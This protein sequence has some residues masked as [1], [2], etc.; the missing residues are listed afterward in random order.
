MRL[1]RITSVYSGYEY[2][3]YQ[4]YNVWNS[5]YKEQKSKYDYDS[6]GWAGSWCNALKNIGYETMEFIFNMNNMQHTW[7]KE[8][9]FSSNLSLDDIVIAQIKWF[10]PEILWFDEVN[11]NLLR[12]I[13]NECNSIKLILGWVGSAIAKSPQWREIDVVLSCA[14]ES[15]EYLRYQG[16]NAEALFHAF[17]PEINSR[18]LSNTISLDAVFIGQIVRDKDFHIER[19]KM[20]LQIA[21]LIELKIYSPS[22]NFS[23]KDILEGYLKK[24][25]YKFVNTNKLN[26]KVIKLIPKLNKSINWDREPV[27][28]VNVNLRKFFKQPVFGIE[29]FQIIK[30]SLITL[31]IH[32]DTSPLYA[33]NMRLFE[34]TGVG[35]GLLTDWKKNIGEL[36]NDGIEI[37]TY[38]SSA[39]CVEKIKWLYD[40]PAKAKEIALAGKKRCMKDHTFSSRVVMLDDIIKKYLN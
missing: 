37:V 28:P 14:P 13:K 21:K 6:F 16:C 8:N 15:V 31:N 39:D 5:S 12:R 17:D 22:F 25:L 20:L 23:Y 7:A 18:L 24:Y 33:S 36:F 34:V 10:K 9:L 29:M 40:H 3:F 32:A 2:Y 27:I 1:L 26:K 11:V 4:K 19:E 30:D 38:K 35:G